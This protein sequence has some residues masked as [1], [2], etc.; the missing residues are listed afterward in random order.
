MDG[1]NEDANK[2][3]S[4]KAIISKAKGTNDS[5]EFLLGINLSNE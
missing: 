2:Q 4:I 3:R 5:L 1:N